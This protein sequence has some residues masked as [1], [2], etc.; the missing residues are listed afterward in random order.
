MIRVNYVLK[1][2]PGMS[3]EEF[4]DYFRN[5]Y[6]PLVAKHQSTLDLHRY[7]QSYTFLDDPVG[8]ALRVARPEMHEPFDGTAACWWGTRDR[9]A[10]A[11]ASPA[12]VAAID[13]LVECER[14]FVDHSGSSIF[15]AREVPQINP[16]PEDGI[17]ARS[18]SPVVKLIYVLHAL[19]ALG[20]DKCHEWWQSRHGAITRR[21]G[22]AMGFLRYIQSHSFDDPMNDALRTRR[23][24]LAPYDGLTE[25]WFDRLHLAD[26]MRNPEC[27]GAEGFDMLLAD[28]YK[29]VDLSRSSTWFSKEHV[30][31][32][33]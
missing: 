30:L 17:L 14:K 8:E 2:T 26:V 3:R 5:V 4:R 21:Y 31:V 16:M 22:A 6:G 12:G 15:L 24:T 11:L 18:G 19:P 33:R 27:E 10:S 9:M 28:E 20:R 25:V 23:G 29:F 13:E 32:E 7:V 1:R